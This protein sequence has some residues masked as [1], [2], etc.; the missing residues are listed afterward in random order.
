M[1]DMNK[2]SLIKADAA[3]TK[4]RKTNYPLKLCKLGEHVLGLSQ[5]FQ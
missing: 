2:K 4:V 3:V 1:G 5:A